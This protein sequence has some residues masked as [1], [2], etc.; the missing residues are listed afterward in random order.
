[1][2]SRGGGYLERHYFY[3]AIC[4]NSKPTAGGGSIVSVQAPGARGL[5]G[6]C[7]TDPKL[8]FRSAV[9]GGLGPAQFID[10]PEIAKRRKN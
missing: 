8:T 10:R 5:P 1:M 7:R 9:S 4:H 3:F 6:A 2:F